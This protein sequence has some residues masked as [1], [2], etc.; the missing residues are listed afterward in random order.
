MEGD[1]VERGCPTVSETI[2]L[3]G[4]SQWA[5]SGRYVIKKIGEGGTNMSDVWST[6]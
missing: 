3:E 2:L 5:A 4:P 6:R 1:L